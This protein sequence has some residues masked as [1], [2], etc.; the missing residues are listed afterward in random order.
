MH[1]DES[2]RKLLKQLLDGACG[3]SALPQYFEPTAP[4]AATGHSNY[5][6][7]TSFQAIKLLTGALKQHDQVFPCHGKG[8]GD[9]QGPEVE[10]DSSSLIMSLQG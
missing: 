6:F 7:A 9:G 10:M 4:A 2:D 8:L 1:V 3:T 5:S